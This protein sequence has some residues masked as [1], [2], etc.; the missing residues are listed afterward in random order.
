MKQAQRA[1]WAAGE[2]DDVA[3]FTIGVGTKLL[4]RIG[5]EPGMEV[6]DVGTGSGGSVAIPAALRGSKVIGLDLTPELLEHARRR[7]EAAGVDVGWVEGDAEALPFE[8]DRFDRVI[9]TFGHICAPR[10][11]VAAAELARV[12]RRDGV[13]A[14]T[15]W[16]ADS[17]PARMFHLV[18]S[19]M[20]PPPAD[21]GDLVAWGNEEY[22]RAMLEPHGVHVEFVHDAAPAEFES[23][24]A[25]MSFYE[26]KSGGL[27]L[28]RS[29]LEPQGRW[30]DLRADLST[31]LTESNVTQ[32]DRLRIEPEY[33][34]TIASWRGY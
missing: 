27:V 31:L 1:S 5:V 25:A 20:P 19:Y 8:A 14:F 4:D 30:A 2:W 26:Q 10:H 12:C 15:S 33:L 23:V 18:S 11:A 32:G 7:A 24:E 17:S 9:S 13:I 16:T 6:L 29:V 34:V 22:V 21:V 3:E 28:A